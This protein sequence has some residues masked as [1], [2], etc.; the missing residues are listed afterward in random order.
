MGRE[1]KKICK[2]CVYYK[3]YPET[4]P[5]WPVHDGTCEN[6]H[7]AVDEQSN[8]PEGEGLIASSDSAYHSCEL[9]VG[10]NFGCIYFKEKQDE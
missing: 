3:P 6:K 5:N 1:M 10:E 4:N 7:I 9:G 8:V 2:N